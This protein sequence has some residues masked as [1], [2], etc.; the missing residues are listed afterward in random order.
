MNLRFNGVYS[1]DNLPNKIKDGAYVINLDEQS[2]IGTH[3]KALYVNA[4]TITYF[5]SFWV[6]HTSKE[7]KKF[8]N[9][10]NRIQPYDS[11]MC[12]YFC[13]DLLILCLKAIA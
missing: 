1:R 10:N 8:I 2:D 5:D 4:K 6:E 13:F 7:I 12:A 11:V 3:S 9:N